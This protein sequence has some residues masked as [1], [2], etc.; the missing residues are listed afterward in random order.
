MDWFEG[1]S[2]KE[3]KDRTDR[4]TTPWRQPILPDLMV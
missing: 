3:R 4:G 2:R 1:E